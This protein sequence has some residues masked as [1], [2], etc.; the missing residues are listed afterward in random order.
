MK[1]KLSK[2]FQILLVTILSSFNITANE[3]MYDLTLEGALFHTT[4]TN[5]P[6]E[7]NLLLIEENGIWHRIWAEAPS[8]NKGI[9]HG[10]ILKSEISDENIK[11]EIIM[12]IAPDA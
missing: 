12:D 4:P 6:K 7:L 2:I 5:N 9:H 8:Y 1:M 11:L 3:K 10:Y